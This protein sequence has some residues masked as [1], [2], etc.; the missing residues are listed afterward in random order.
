MLVSLVIAASQVCLPFFPKS[1]SSSYGLGE[2]GE[3][4]VKHSPPHSIAL[5]SLAAGWQGGRDGERGTAE[6]KKIYGASCC[7]H[8][9]LM[10]LP[11]QPSSPASHCGGT[12]LKNIDTAKWS[13]KYIES[14]S[15]RK[16]FFLKDRLV[17]WHHLHNLTFLCVCLTDLSFLHK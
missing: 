17:W 14:S 5:L 15:A 11:L 1:T 8:C 12:V 4:G 7:V 2:G 10:K 13:V 6:K 16:S 3:A 9:R